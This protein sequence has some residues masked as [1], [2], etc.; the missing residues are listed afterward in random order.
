MNPTYLLPFGFA[1]IISLLATPL[2]KR[3]AFKIGA[4]DEPGEARRIHSRPT[5]RL[6]GLAVY[7][8]IM[9]GALLYLNLDWRLIALLLAV[10]VLVVVGIV[11]DIKGLSPGVK[12]VWQIVAAG[13]ALSGGIGIVSL[14]NPLGGAIDL[15]FGRFAVDL[16]PW[17]FH[18]TPLGN[19]LSIFW[20]VGMVNVINFLDGLD[21]LATGV[22]GIAA[23]ALFA[24]SIRVNQPQTA[25]LA[26]IVAG[27]ALGFLPFNFNPARIFLGDSGAYSLG[28]MLAMIA[29]FSGSKL[30]TAALVLGFPIL[31]GV[32]TVVRRLAKGISPF[33]A[34]RSHLHHLMLDAG[35]SQ[36]QVVTGLYAFTLIFGSVA[37]LSGSRV[38]LVALVAL[39]FSMLLMLRTL[40]HLNRKKHKQ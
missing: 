21:G 24:L 18:I 15:T 8:S 28:L 12:L 13:L 16:G 1:L 37:V 32:W 38:K 6:G 11:D 17:H 26:L 5:A 23:L 39:T 7:V 22:S 31:D 3:L 10:T 9:L 4:V 40:A 30:A 33:R 20:M 36:R 34:D 19:L 35:L 27:A 29:I 25:I 2:I 14:T